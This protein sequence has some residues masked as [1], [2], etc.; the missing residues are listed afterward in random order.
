MAFKLLGKGFLSRICHQGWIGD[1]F[2]GCFFVASL[3]FFFQLKEIHVDHLSLNTTSPKY[4]VSQIGFEFPDPEATQLLRDESIRDLG[5]IYFISSK[6][7]GKI[8]K[9]IREGL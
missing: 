1:L 7:V 3:A 2:L 9:R 8:E 6:E 4:I 5:K